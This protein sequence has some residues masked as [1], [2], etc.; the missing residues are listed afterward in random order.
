MA[1]YNKFKRSLLKIKRPWT[2]LSGLLV[3]GRLGVTFGRSCWSAQKRG[4]HEMLLTASLHGHHLRN[5]ELTG[6][7]RS[8]GRHSRRTRLILSSND[9]LTGHRWLVGS[10]VL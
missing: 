4:G 6:Q 9:G 1:V 10:V 3:I 8:L 5:R 2:A 7:N